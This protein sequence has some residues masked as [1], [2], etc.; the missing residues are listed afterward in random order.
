MHFREQVG[1]ALVT[2]LTLIG[3]LRLKLDGLV[4][5]VVERVLI[6]AIGRAYLV[7]Q[8]PQLQIH[9]RPRL[10]CRCPSPAAPVITPLAQRRRI[11]SSSLNHPKRILLKLGLCLAEIQLLL[12][13]RGVV[14]ASLL[15]VCHLLL[16]LILDE[17]LGVRHFIRACA[18]VML[19]AFRGH[20]DRVHIILLLL[21]DS[22]GFEG[23][24]GQLGRVLL[25]HFVAACLVYLMGVV[26]VMVVICAVVIV[27]EALRNV[28]HLVG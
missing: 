14:V 10:K 11:S 15:S 16:L 2:F 27:V 12:G 9:L 3:K 7:L 4:L 25:V 24:R 20:C 23:R 17:S 13:G 1:F 18:R 19:V 5:Q 8:V 28:R 6:L 26:G 21:V 22:A